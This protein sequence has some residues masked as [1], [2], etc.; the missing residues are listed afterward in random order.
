MENLIDNVLIASI[1]PYFLEKGF[2]WFEENLQKITAARKT[3]SFFEDNTVI[4]EKDQT[5]N[6][7]ELLRKIDEMGYEKVLKV[8]DPGEFSV[9]GG[10]MGIF[11]INR[12]RAIR[13]DFLGNKI[14]II[15]EI[16]KEIEDE[17]KSKEILKKK[18][19][20][21]R[22]YSD[23][24]NLKVGEY[25]VHLD[26]GIGRFMGF[27]KID[28]RERN[29]ENYYIL[30]YG[31]GDKLYVPV[32]LERKISRFVGFSEPKLSRL[33]SPV[34]QITKRKMKEN[35]IKLAKELLE[36]EANRKISERE[37]F[38]QNNELDEK[39]ISSFKYEETPDQASAIYDIK[40]DLEKNKPMDRLIAGDVGFGKTEVALRAAIKV[41]NSGAMA[42]ILSPTT[43]LACQHYQNFEKRLKDLPINVALLTRLQGKKEKEKIIKNL[44]ESKIDILIGTHRL[45]SKEIIDLL[46]LKDGRG[47]LVIDDE[48]R[49]GVKQKEKLKQLRS[50]IDILSLSATP[51]P[52]TLHLAL[53]AIKEISL[54]QTPPEGRLPVRTFVAPWS[55]DMIKDAIKRETSRGG[56]VYYLHNKIESME[57]I[58]GF[59]QELVPESKIET[60]H[61]RMPDKDLIRAISNFQN[62]KA[63]ILISTT[64]IENGIDLA[65]VNTL[66]V[67][68]SANL[69]LSQAYQLKGR[70]GRSNV[71]GFAY[72][73]HKEKM[74]EKAKLR[75]EALEEMQELGAGYRVALR[76]LEIRGAG[77]ILGR[78]Q[79]GSIN[80]VGLNLY[81]Q[82]LSEAVEKLKS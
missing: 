10:V 39:I 74:G 50:K 40:R 55:K 36:V 47:L 33:S 26:H 6:L 21:Q 61:A 82:M 51:I 45:F 52:R 65:N 56:Q 14:E 11:P 68:D 60:I 66:I 78:E 63:D 12:K 35:A 29:S 53:S 67:D 7:Y 46:F 49:F 42:C 8:E 54:I 62:K 2:V 57:G 30:E 3:Q 5:I 69:G 20:S 18:L 43:I 70:V 37:P 32:G 71:Q 59:V 24:K 76:D 81:C 80:K 58:R 75:L 9:L 15:E 48:Q 77:N 28:F 38:L 16:G 27:E 31:A 73:F 72:F 44:K 79:S 25:L 4:L 64:I 13:L 19:K 22:I 1:T 34:W 23:I 41:A 17:E